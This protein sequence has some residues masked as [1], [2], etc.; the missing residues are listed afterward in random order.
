MRLLKIGLAIILALAVA[1]LL[2]K[3]AAGLFKFAF[4]LI[5]WV[6]VAIIAIP[7]FLYLKNKV[8]K[9]GSGDRKYIR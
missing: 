6:L 2:I 5:G 7:I 1:W 8:F 9:L 3:L 4:A